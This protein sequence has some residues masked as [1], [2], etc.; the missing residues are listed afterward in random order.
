MKQRQARK[1]KKENE[2]ENNPQKDAETPSIPNPAMSFESTGDVERDRK[3]RNILKNK[4]YILNPTLPSCCFLR[5]GLP[6][7]SDVLSAVKGLNNPLLNLESFPEPFWSSFLSP[8]NHQGIKLVE[9]VN[10]VCWG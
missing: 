1:A 10:G 4:Y 9:L 3:I 5:K 6:S 8:L 2:R 7:N